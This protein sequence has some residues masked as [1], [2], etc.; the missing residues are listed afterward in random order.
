MRDCF[1]FRNMT[2]L[3]HGWAVWHFYFD[4]YDHIYHGEELEYMWDLPDQFCNFMRGHHGKLLTLDDAR[5][6]AVYHDCGK[7]MCLEVDGIGRQHFPN[8]AI[9]SYETWLSAGGCEDIGWYILHDMDLHS[10]NGDCIMGLLRDTRIFALLLMAYAE[11]HSNAGMFGG[12]QSTSFKIK[13][14]RL[15]KIFKK[16][17]TVTNGG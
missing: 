4:L 17:I 11:I 14:N 9:R 7:P 8:H 5:L 10:A 3:D 12:I 1:Q 6:Y 16:L 2:I 15:D 13:R